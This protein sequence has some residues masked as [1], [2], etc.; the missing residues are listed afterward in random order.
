M[1]PEGPTFSGYGNFLAQN[2][3]LDVRCCV[4]LCHPYFLR[5]YFTLYPTCATVSCC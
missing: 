3:V 4:K 2:K 1:I 5:Q